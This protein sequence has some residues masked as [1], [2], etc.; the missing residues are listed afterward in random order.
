MGESIDKVVTTIAELIESNLMKLAEQKAK[1]E[2]EAAK[3]A[4]SAEAAQAA[5]RSSG[6][7]GGAAL[8]DNSVLR[9]SMM[10]QTGIDDDAE[11][12]DNASDSMEEIE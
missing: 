8:R 12:H 5:D 3:L 9:P 10:L 11:D 7:A 4:T 1:T 2:A 6:K